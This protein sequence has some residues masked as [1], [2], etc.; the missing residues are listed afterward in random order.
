[1]ATT[2]KHPDGIVTTVAMTATGAQAITIVNDGH[3]LIDGATV[4]A[5]GN[6]T[7]NLTVGSEITKGATLLITNKTNGTETLTHGTI[8]TA[9][10]I[11]GSAGKTTSQAFTYDGAAFLP[12]GAKIQID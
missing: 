6:R 7:V 11:T 12:D 5:T 4:E 10:V 1:M 2:I 8:I 9:P 3:T